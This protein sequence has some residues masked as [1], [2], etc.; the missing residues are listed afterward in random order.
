MILKAFLLSALFIFNPHSQADEPENQNGRVT[1]LSSSIW[2]RGFSAAV[3]DLCEGAKQDCFQT[4]YTIDPYTNDESA[5]EAIK[6]GF[7]KNND[8]KTKLVSISNDQIGASLKE[9]FQRAQI[10]KNP[11]TSAY[12]KAVLAQLDRLMTDYKVSAFEAISFSPVLYHQSIILLI[13]NEKFDMGEAIAIGAG[14]TESF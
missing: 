10:Q 2:M 5:A 8:L 1:N 7:V 4:S 3:K 11:T 14:P 9:L 12:A 6:I 13:R